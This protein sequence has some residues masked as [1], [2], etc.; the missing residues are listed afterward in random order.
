MIILSDSEDEGQPLSPM[1]APPPPDYGFPVDHPFYIP[2]PDSLGG[3][4]ATPLLHPEDEPE[5]IV[6][7]SDDD[8]EGD[9]MDFEDPP[10]SPPA[11]EYV[12]LATPSEDSDPMEPEFIEISDS[13]D[14][15]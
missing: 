10:L 15:M 6:I 14:G 12:D 9:Y 3:A 1:P 4:S 7:I 13:D 2:S 8:V 11:P 5:D